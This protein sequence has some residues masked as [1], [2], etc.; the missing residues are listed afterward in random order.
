M[1]LSKTTLTAAIKAGDLTWSV[2]SV[3]GFPV[4]G[5]VAASQPVMVDDEVAFCVGVPN[6]NQII[7]RSRGSDGSIADAH[8]IG[9]VVI[10]SALP[11]DFPTTA[12]GAFVT[13]PPAMPDVDFYGQ[14]GAIA[15]PVQDT[16]AYLGGTAALAMTLG[17]PGLANNGMELIITSQTAFAHVITTVSL[18]NT[19]VAGSPFNTATFPAAIGAS[20]FLVAQNGL[21]NVITAGVSGMVFA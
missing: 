4:V 13:R 15:V 20:L 18:L 12:P 2:A 3:A 6:V 21:W 17:A 19:G 5:T 10:T 1:P 16:K 9:A 8:D 7:V 11:S 14:N